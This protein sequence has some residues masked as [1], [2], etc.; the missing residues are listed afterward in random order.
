V[1]TDCRGSGANSAWHRHDA[2]LEAVTNHQRVSF[3]QR[4]RTGQSTEI[5]AIVAV[6][7]DHEAALARRRCSDQPH[8]RS[9]PLALSAAPVCP[10]DRLRSI[11]G[12]VGDQHC[13]RRR[14][15]R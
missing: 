11:G 12:A 5:I 14:F 8:C 15:G 13:R 7:H 3:A 4:Q 1:S 9:T 2:A 6:S 10:R